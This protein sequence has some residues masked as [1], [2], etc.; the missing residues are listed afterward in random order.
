MK[1]KSTLNLDNVYGKVCVTDE[2]M[3]FR[4]N[5]TDN[6]IE[7]VTDID[8]ENVSGIT[9]TDSLT[10]YMGDDEKRHG[11][12]NMTISGNV[13]VASDADGLL[14]ETGIAY[15]TIMKGVANIAEG[16]TVDMSV[17]TRLSV[18]S[19]AELA[20]AGTLTNV[21]KDTEAKSITTAGDITVTGLIQASEEIDVTGSGVVNAAMYED[22]D[23]D[24]FNYTTLAKAISAGATD[25]TIT[26]EVTIDSDVTIPVGTTVNSEAAVVTIDEN[27]TLTVAAQGTDS[28]KFKNGTVNV[29]GTMVVQNDRKSNVDADEIVSDV[30]ST[31]GT[32][33]TYTNVYK[34]LAEADPN[35]VVTI[36]KTGTGADA[37]I[38]VLDKNLEIPADV[39]LEIPSGKTVQVSPG[40]TVTVNGTLSIEEGQ[41]KMDGKTD[42]KAAGKT[43]VNGLLEATD[44]TEDYETGDSQIV[45]AY[46]IYNGLNCIAPLSYAASVINDVESDVRTIGNVVA[47]DVAFNYT[48]G[49]DY[50]IVVAQG[51]TLKAGTITLSGIDLDFTAGTINATVAV[52]DGSFILKDVTGGI[53]SDVV[54]VDENDV[55]SNVA[56]LTGDVAN[57]T[58]PEKPSENEKLEGSVTVAGNVTI[59]VDTIT[60]DLIIPSDAVA[61]IAG[62][63]Y[64]D[65][66]VSIDGTMTIA[67]T[68]IAFGTV[69]VMGT[70]DIEEDADATVTKVYVGLAVDDEKNKITETGAG[71][72]TGLTLGTAGVA[73]VTPESTFTAISSEAEDLVSTEYYIDDALYMTA[74]A[75]GTSVD[76]P[77]VDAQV[78]NAYF[79]QWQNSEKI[80]IGDDTYVGAEKFQQVYA[81]IDYN[82]YVVQVIADEGIGTVYLDGK[83]MTKLSN[84]FFLYE[85]GEQVELAAGQHEISFVLKNSFS[86]DVKMYVNGEAVSGYTF[87]LQGT[88]DN[89]TPVIYTINLVGVEPTAPVTPS[90]GDSGDDGMGLTDYLLIILV[91]LIVIMAI[92]VALRLMR[93]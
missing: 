37:G 26:G 21:D 74:Y 43:V 84:A 57:A 60:T 62:G 50:S 71:A 36:T 90:T 5:N 49:D 25:I 56:T 41:Y 82:I 77:D 81:E 16:A 63:N 55:E 66:A 93:S 28:A 2:D 87:T 78:E 40:V 44:S 8:F 88:N 85:G 10:T 64:T 68:G 20:V 31:D 17:D 32:G 3:K 47:Q 59:D 11:K 83:V 42:T 19:G 6:Q 15:I 39:T 75:Y 30:S 22:K 65:A 52:A 53:V 51:S 7:N 12:G 79:E 72:V 27:A 48:T 92:M 46:F 13:D 89:E 76:I 1:D 14:D 18:S 86:G 4:A 24:V 33:S 70:V 67:G 23:A 61:K 91:V 54:V 38:V 35:D 58:N 73:I 45:G 29:D 80:A 69:T 34:A 9:V